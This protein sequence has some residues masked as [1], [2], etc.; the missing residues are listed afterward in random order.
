M[1]NYGVGGYLKLCSDFFETGNFVRKN[2]IFMEKIQIFLLSSKNCD[3][4]SSGQESNF[5]PRPIN[6]KGNLF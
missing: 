2:K 6:P 1:V 4:I 3:M 5:W